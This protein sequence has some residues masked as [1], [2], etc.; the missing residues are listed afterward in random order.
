M[1]GFGIVNKFTVAIELQ[2]APEKSTNGPFQRTFYDLSVVIHMPRNIHHLQL[3]TGEHLNNGTSIHYRG[4]H[5]VT[6]VPLSKHINFY[7]VLNHV[8]VCSSRHPTI[9]NLLFYKCIKTY[10]TSPS[11]RTKPRHA[12]RKIPLSTYFRFGSASCTYM[13][14]P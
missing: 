1:R 10:G 2:S 14:P 8:I 3:S 11:H 5:I 12:D 6:T 7:F 4:R 13:V 9:F